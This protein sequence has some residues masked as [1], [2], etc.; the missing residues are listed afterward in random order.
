MCV[1][2]LYTWKETTVPDRELDF[3]VY[4]TGHP[5]INEGCPKP[6]VDIVVRHIAYYI[7]SPVDPFLEIRKGFFN[8]LKQ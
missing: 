3:D 8:P 4:S 7:R 6:I 2:D 1:F 5:S